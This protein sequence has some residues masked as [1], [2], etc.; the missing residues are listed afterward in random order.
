MLEIELIEPLPTGVR[1]ID[2]FLT[3]GRGQRIGILAG[4]GVGKSTLL[5]MF[6]RGTAADLTVIALIGERGREVRDFIEQDLG[7]DALARSL[8]PNQGSLERLFLNLERVLLGHARRELGA[9]LE[10]HF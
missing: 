5:G 2:G 8:E 3:L 7:A 10:H 6:A 4:S 9:V 1:A